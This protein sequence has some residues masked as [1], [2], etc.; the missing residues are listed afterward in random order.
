MDADAADGRY[1]RAGAAYAEGLRAVYQPIPDSLR[2]FARRTDVPFD[3]TSVSRFLSGDRVAPPQFIDCLGVARRAVDAPLTE[4][5]QRQLRALWI[6]VMEASSN[7]H[8]RLAFLEHELGAVRERLLEAEARAGSDRRRIETSQARLQALREELDE[9]RR[10]AARTEALH[11]ENAWLRRQLTAAADYVKNTERQLGESERRSTGLRETL[12]PLEH[13]VAVLRR[14][15][16]ALHA[17]APAGSP[18]LAGGARNAT[19]AAEDTAGDVLVLT[20]PKTISRIASH[21]YTRWQQGMLWTVG[22]GVCVVLPMWLNSSY[23]WMPGMDYAKG[24]RPSEHSKWCNLE[25]GCSPAYLS[26]EIP[27][28]EAISAT[29]WLDISDASQKPRGT[30]DIDSEDGCAVSA[31]WTVTAGGS[32]VVS[33]TTMGTEP[34][35]VTGTAPAHSGQLTFSAQRTDSKDCQA[36]LNW[37]DAR[38]E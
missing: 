36:T 31:E 28:G 1:Q 34:V 14:Q 30:I 2:A 35:S 3:Y 21:R 15:V 20:L 19:E 16:E 17:E 5:E 7:P 13:E 33:A 11:E 32:R 37:Y 4:A 25:T 12:A 22:V 18:A 38:V 29:F 8:H 27:S 6:A 10:T 26:L 24:D 23:D 9:A